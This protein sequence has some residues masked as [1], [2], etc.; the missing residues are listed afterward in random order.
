MMYNKILI[1]EPIERTIKIIDKI[2][3]KS[4]VGCTKCYRNSQKVDKQIVVILT[5]M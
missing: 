4:R 3:E 1:Q 2:K 5:L